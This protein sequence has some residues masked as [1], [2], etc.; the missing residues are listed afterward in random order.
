MFRKSS[1]LS[2]YLWIALIF[3]LIL[4]CINIIF[5]SAAIFTA[6]IYNAFS[7]STPDP[8]MVLLETQVAILITNSAQPQT[9]QPFQTPIPE[10][11]PTE[12]IL[13]SLTSEI[14][15][16]AINESPLTATFT[17]IPTTT[18]IHTPT[19]SKFPITRT[20]TNTP[21]TPNPNMTELAF[22][23]YSIVEQ[24]YAGNF[25]STVNGTYYRIEDYESNWTQTDSYQKTYTGYDFPNFVIRADATWQ[26]AASA[27]GADSGCGIIFH[28]DETEDHYLVVYTLG[29]RAILFRRMNG[30]L[31]KLGTSF[32]YEVDTELAQAEIMIVVEDNNIQIWANDGSKPLYE[33]K[34]IYLETGEIAFTV[35][36]GSTLDYGTRC[37]L[38]NIDLWEIVK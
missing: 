13:P 30:S 27:L 22:P 28:E 9:D 33:M 14:I 7:L 36:T 34:H 4:F 38:R 8:S 37:E 3:T 2:S 20:P 5:G 31:S 16:S 21:I 1:P 25:I 15:S 18:S 12:G 10:T 29:D 23:M 26:V 11:I 17:L 24:L 6:A 32:R 19:P 35:I